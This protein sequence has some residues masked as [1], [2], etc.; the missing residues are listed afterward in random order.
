MQ[1][2]AR[3]AA[4]DAAGAAEPDGGESSAGD[5]DGE[6][7]PGLAAAAVCAE[8][9]AGPVD[10]IRD[11]M[12]GEGGDAPGAGDA[13]DDWARAGVEQRVSA[14]GAGVAAADV[15]VGGHAW[16]PGAALP[17]AGAGVQEGLY[18]PPGYTWLSAVGAGE[19]DRLRAAWKA[20]EDAEVDGEDEG[21]ERGLLDPWQRFA[22][23]IVVSSGA[24]RDRL[25]ESV[26]RLAKYQPLRLILTGMA[27]T[28][29]SRTVRAFVKGRR[30]VLRKGKPR[31]TD[32]SVKRCCILAAPTGCASFQMRF[33]AT[34]VHRAF[35]VRV[36]YCGPWKNTKADGYRKVY[37]ALK[38]A[39]LA[40]I[41][42]FSMVGRQFFGK[43]LY[44]VENMMGKDTA[45]L[46]CPTDTMAAMDVVLSGHPAQAGPIADDRF[47]K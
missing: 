14:A 21:V 27:G 28:G 18:N 10:M 19:K 7:D 20:W 31:A 47:W 35:G 42:E 36:G 41:D 37:E 39:K 45:A 3:A 44:R 33:G 11:P 29:K 16:L 40:V 32:A 43:I 5:T 23:D 38:L 1:A 2:D 30:G 13:D 4:A 34:T 46:R 17:A 25:D 9:R 26:E 22:H 8:A 12:P 24:E 6:D 15:V